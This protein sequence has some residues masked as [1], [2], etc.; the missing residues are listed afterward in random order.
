MSKLIEYTM[1]ISRTIVDK[2]GVKLY[3]KVSAVLGELI[4]NAYDADA[5]E[6]KI[7]APMDGYLATRTG[8]K[9]VDGGFEIRIEDNGHG[10]TPAEMGDFYLVVGS[11][12]RTDGRGDETKRKRKIMGRKGVGK[13]A[14]FGICS[15]IEIISA[16][17]EKTSANGK[18]GYLTSH[19]TLDYNEITESSEIHDP[20]KPTRGEKDNTISPERGTTVVL[21][22]FNRRR[23][24]KIDDLSRQIAQRFGIGSD[25]W[26]ITLHDNK[27]PKGSPESLN[28]GDFD[29][30]WAPDTIIEFKGDKVVDASNSV[31][32][33]L[34]SGFWHEEKFHPVTGW[35]AYSKVPYKDELMAGIRIY[36]RKKIVSQTM[37]F[38]QK[39]GFTGE[40]DIRSYL[41]GQLEADWLD[42]KDD[43]IQTDRRDILWSDDLCAAFQDWGQ[44]VV[45]RVGTMARDPMR[46]KASELFLETGE[47]EARATGAYPAE[48]QSDIRNK[49]IALATRFGRAFSLAE[50]ADEQV[51]GGY[52][53]LIIDFAPHITFDEKMREAAEQKD[54]P[55][56]VL[57]AILRTARVAELSSFGRVV[58]E[59]I[60]I[61][62]RL[63]VLKD[64]EATVESELQQLIERA[65]WLINPEWSLITANQGLRTFRDEFE[66]H[67]QKGTGMAISIADFDEPKK[68]PDFV[69]T[70]QKGVV[71]IVEIKRP[72][73]HKLG[74]DEMDRIVTYHNQMEKFLKNPANKS[75]TQNMAEF[76]I[77]LV[78]DEIALS[79][80]HQ[81][82]FDGYIEK[83]VMTYMDWA[84]FLGK[85]KAAHQD[86]LKKARQQRARAASKP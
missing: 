73:P 50:A 58:Q 69:L 29:V 62:D 48:N 37:L 22:N 26:R 24:A 68:R 59:R 65:P 3:D 70:T 13:L 8:G 40:H 64:R 63:K 17:G 39:A 5:T 74:D 44:G 84:S 35:V 78:C 11:D 43:L 28:I 52:V 56:E 16:G 80:T 42:D 19:L 33:K 61:M 10:M 45:K 85:T 54:T 83:R 51:V 21:R 79:A 72:S 71:Q 25:D 1:R 38:N 14:P 46:K 82:A 49:A 76:H 9:I 67:F 36:C 32:S 57:S 31:V 23:V 6:V 86:F 81:A 15:V 75:I 18:S 34:E 27:E 53:D 7:H 55:I 30:E 12:R 77:T 47:V 4:A 41:I 20:Y 60:G 2:L 66:K